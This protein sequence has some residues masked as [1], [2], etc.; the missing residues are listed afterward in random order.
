M[1]RA[2]LIFCLFS[3]PLYAH[4]GLHEQIEA[5]TRAIASAPRNAALYLQRGELHRLHE[6]WKDAERDYDRARALQPD[7]YGVDLAHGR[8]LFDSGRVREAIAPLQRYVRT[9]PHDAH[10]RI[11]LARALASTGRPAEAVKEFEA[12]LAVQVEPDLALEYAR[13]LTAAGRSNDALR[14]LDKLPRLVTIELAAIELELSAGN[15]EGALRR[16]DA[17]QARAAR[18]EDWLERRGDLLMKLG[19]AKE[20]RAAYQA[21]LDAI[22]TLPP[23]RRHTRAASALERRLREALAR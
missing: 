8:M 14:Y 23:E 1:R 5:V 16:V 21:A 3:A 2:L 19:R 11:S 10:G 6:E 7:L 4:R 13:A 15:V 17:A 20:A 12:A 9:A 22:S 18:K